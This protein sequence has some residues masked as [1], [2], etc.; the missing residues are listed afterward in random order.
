MTWIAFLQTVVI[1][2]LLAALGALIFA[3][4]KLRQHVARESLYHCLVESSP[5]SLEMFD[6]QGRYV[7]VNQGGLVAM[8]WRREDVI[9]RRYADVWPEHVRPSVERAIQQVL[10]GEKCVFEAETLRADGAPVVL[11]VMLTPVPDADHKIRRFVGISVDITGRKAIE[12]ALVE[13]EELLKATLESTAD[14]ILVVSDEDRVILT[15]TR[16]AAIWRISRCG[17]SGSCG[18]AVLEKVREQLVNPPDLAS[19]PASPQGL[20]ACDVLQCRDGRV[21][22]RHCQPLVQS[23]RVAGRVWSFRDVTDRELAQQSM[24]KENAKFN[25]IISSME[26]GILFADAENRVLE[27][28]GCFCRLLNRQRRDLLGRRLDEIGRP[29]LV[30]CATG[31]VDEFRRHADHPPLALQRSVGDA[32]VILRVRPIYRAGCYDGVLLNVMNV[33]EVIKAQ[34]Q[35]EEARAAAIEANRNLDA[36]NR[37]LERTIERANRMAVE[38][39]QANQSKSEFLANISHEIRTPMTAIL[40]YCDLLLDGDS[41]PQQQHQYLDV[42][43]RNGHHLLS[44]INDI[45]DLSKIEAGRMQV[46]RLAC[47]PL[48]IMEEVVS[49]MRVRALQKNLVLEQDYQFPLPEVIQSDPIR[50]RQILVNLV[51]NAIKFTH[52]GAVRLIARCVR[53]GARTL[54]A[55]D[56]CDTGIG[57]K[58]EQ[59]ERLFRPFTQADS[60]HSRVYGGTGLGLTISRRLAQAMGGDIHVRS[61]PGQG[62]TFSALIDPGPLQNVRM[63]EALTDFTEAP[64]GSA[65]ANADLRLAGRFL[66]AEDGVDN[67]HLISTMLRKAGAEVELAENGR[68]AVEK[69]LAAEQDGRGYAAILM[70]IQMPE[71]D[72]Y[73]AT[74][75][76]RKHGYSRPIIAL[77]AHAMYSDLQ[78]CLKAGCDEYT[79]K[80]VNR[81]QL[82]RLLQTVT[83]DQAQGAPGAS[84]ASAGGADAGGQNFLARRMGQA[85]QEMRSATAHGDY[86]RLRR[87]AHEYIVPLAS[88]N[89]AE[90]DEIRRRLETASAEQDAESA[91]LALSELE[92]FRSQLVKT[93]EDQPQSPDAIPAGDAGAECGPPAGEK[94]E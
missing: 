65:P 93:E 68:V 24:E 10:A 44:L 61:T 45:L 46:E 91:V 1:V 16:F 36:A 57:M 75:Y 20:H 63:L 30:G 18:Q 32:E 23:G 19:L 41:P 2:A 60:S 58:K 55:F 78:K 54:L 6:S 52:K 83:A 67:Q 40:G 88:D 34:R 85:L 79:T 77:T 86:A 66:L 43:R 64:Q 13:R 15:N 59:M 29:D 92:S 47:Q 50:L 12:K 3:R 48:R 70:D 28:N 87:L 51:G 25:A 21:I 76:L 42:I 81:Q 62:S 53:G 90:L 73:E 49:L 84:A 4:N 39:E 8:G 17:G 7:T 38:A 94:H 22:E 56:V 26:D 71:M 33:T 89:F 11:R 27:V 35:A 14:G 31:A 82:I 5:N 80:P 72:G 37:Q 9:G 74:R 69:A